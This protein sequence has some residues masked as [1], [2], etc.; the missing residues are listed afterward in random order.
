MSSSND[1]ER[2]LL[3][4]DKEEEPLEFWKEFFDL[5]SMALQVSLATFTRIALTSIGKCLAWFLGE[6]EESCAS[7][8]SI[9]C[10]CR[11]PCMP[12]PSSA[13]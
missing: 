11:C 5:T 13:S 4:E 9:Y 7:H 12:S 1:E 10:T 3:A 8:R 6:D 2:P